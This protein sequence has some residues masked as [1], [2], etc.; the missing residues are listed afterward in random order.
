[1]FI[2][3]NA[4]RVVGGE[5]PSP[6][7]TASGTASRIGSSPQPGQGGLQGTM[8][9]VGEGG[10][11]ALRDDAAQSRGWFGGVFSALW[12]AAEDFTTAMHGDP[13]ED[14]DSVHDSIHADSD[15][16]DDVRSEVD[17]DGTLTEVDDD[18]EEFFDC[19][20][21]GVA[22]Y[23]ARQQERQAVSGGPTVQPQ[24]L[25]DVPI[26]PLSSL[27]G[28][29]GEAQGVQVQVDTLPARESV[30][31][32]TQQQQEGI[33]G[34]LLRYGGN[35][36]GAVTST[37]ASTA[38]SVART[39]GGYLPGGG[40]PVA[41]SASVA[42]STPVSER[43]L[44]R[45]GEVAGKIDEQMAKLNEQLRRMG[46]GGDALRVPDGERLNTP[47]LST[48]DTLSR[49]NH[50]AR[51]ALSAGLTTL[52]WTT[53]AVAI[54]TA[55]S[56]ITTPMALS[57]TSIGINATAMLGGAYLGLTALRDFP[58]LASNRAA[59]SLVESTLQSLQPQF[60]ELDNLIAQE[61]SRQT[62]TDRTMLVSLERAPRLDALQRELAQVGEALKT[63][64][65]APA[66]GVE[67]RHPVALGD[68]QAR[69]QTLSLAARAKSAF[70]SFFGSIARG[71]SSA[72][73]FLADLPNVPGRL[74]ER[75]AAGKSELAYT[76]G[77]GRSALGILSAPRD[78]GI[79]LGGV[80]VRV[81]QRA[82][83]AGGASL[84]LPDVRRQMHIGENL[85]HALRASDKPAFGAIAVGEGTQQVAATA[86]LTTAR[87]MAWYFAAAADAQESGNTQPPT[88][89]RNTDGSLSVADP[90][91]K[92]YS[93]LMHAPSVHTGAMAGEDG[94]R[95]PGRLTLDDH[96][97]GFPDGARGMQFETALN[98]D[99]GAE[100]RIRFVTER[101]QPVFT[102]LANERAVLL[103]MYQALHSPAQAGEPQ[104]DFSGWSRDRLEA[105][106]S[107]LIAALQRETTL[108][109]GDQQ[110]I[111]ELRDWQNP[112]FLAGRA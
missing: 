97:R 24:A 10:T 5:A 3:P 36:L 70:Q 76:Q 93:F 48:W 63:A 68:G 72:G 21:D 11:A 61:A 41:E 32:Q 95:E 8:V 38:S 31:Q 79:V 75:R 29:V 73:R 42:A 2:N 92:L 4:S 15:V 39:V 35:A 109:A 104:A 46:G 67:S 28:D 14:E 57:P 99:G 90:D 1:M 100:L 88:V 71:L 78:G 51:G 7:D 27:L 25:D 23:N 43:N 112:A 56:V 34:R 9:S 33:M 54:P 103:S 18:D 22:A 74:L 111:R 98:A 52:G 106:Q 107:S 65:S 84:A 102:P 69:T 89:T 91:R 19:D 6:Q 37:V 16:G 110:Q 82:A 59:L 101:A 26:L 20:D 108:M 94:T 44:A 87:A 30:Q 66:Q 47:T 80:D 45:A 58:E 64:P 40:T 60:K 96:R 86:N 55:T 49:W 81:M 77:A 105:H 50:Q 83:D 53:A 85:T 62:A 12:Q 13:L 17:E